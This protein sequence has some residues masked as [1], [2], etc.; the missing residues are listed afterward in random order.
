MVVL[1]ALSCGCTVVVGD[2][3]PGACMRFE[4]CDAL[5]LRDRLDARTCEL[6]TCRFEIGRLAGTCERGPRDRDGDG[7]P[8][9]QPSGMQCAYE[10]TDCDDLDRLRDGSDEVCDG[11]D[12]DCDLAIDETFEAGAFVAGAQPLG[13]LG[14]EGALRFSTTPELALAVLATSTASGLAG[15]IVPLAEGTASAPL[16]YETFCGEATPR[17]GCGLGDCT[18]VSTGCSVGQ[19]SIDRAGDGAW[20]AAVNRTGCDT[21]ELR[22]GRYDGGGHV[23]IDS[24]GSAAFG[25]PACTGE[26]VRAPSIAALDP[27]SGA[28]LALAAHYVEPWNATRRCGE[29]AGVRAVR[30]RGTASA[31]G[32][33]GRFDLEGTIELGRAASIAAPAV[34]ALSD[35]V[36][37]IVA[38]GSASG[39]L[40]LVRVLASGE[41]AP[42]A[43]IEGAAPASRIALA[44]GAAGV[45]VGWIEGCNGG[46]ARFAL[47][48]GSGE[49]I[50]GAPLDEQ[51]D[52][53]VAIALADGLVEPGFTRGGSTAGDAGG[54]LVVTRSADRLR[55]HRVLALD[56]A[57]LAEPQ[58]I[59][60][61]GARAIGLVARPGAAA[62][63]VELHAWRADGELV[64]LTLGCGG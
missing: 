4:D 43:S 6:W 28:G 38:F 55:A 37:W 13:T 57:P 52:D 36:G 27:G 24:A 21:G 39:G 8:G 2:L 62:L 16:S 31:A 11:A 54:W 44:A 33:S 32:R 41:H 19:P 17:A 48:R 29:E 7:A 46:A 40:A 1:A 49:V 14:A 63:P 45:G 12:N 60:L 25:A 56:A 5:N 9:P 42:L 15:A 22:V 53:V 35:R 59:D 64:R 26:G 51:A 58:S 20:V 10:T 23:E 50:G 18:S 3:A 61:A 47:V 30:L 34:A